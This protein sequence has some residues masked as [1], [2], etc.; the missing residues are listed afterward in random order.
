ML[1][2]EAMSTSH[3]Y[4]RQAGVDIRQVWMSSRCGRQA[5][6]DVR[7]VWT[8]DNIVYYIS[9]PLYFGHQRNDRYPAPESVRDDSHNCDSDFLHKQKRYFH[10]FFFFTVKKR[11]IKYQSIIVVKK[12]GRICLPN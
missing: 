7:Q 3:I 9:L 11:Y 8:Y 1:K 10:D 2:A 6:V 4:G 5:G 12:K